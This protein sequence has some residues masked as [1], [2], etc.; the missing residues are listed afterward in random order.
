[1]DWATPDARAAAR[2]TGSGAPVASTTSM[3]PVTIEPPSR[4]GAGRWRPNFAVTRAPVMVP[5]PYAVRITPSTD[6]GR[7]R[8][9]VMW[10]ARADTSG[11]VRIEIE[12]QNRITT[13][14]V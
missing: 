10:T 1:M 11:A 14:S 3:D 9:R 5:T 8:S 4:I 7:P 12:P 13:R 2:K 6:A